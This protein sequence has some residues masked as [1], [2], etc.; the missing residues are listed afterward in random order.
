MR[1]NEQIEEHR[2]GYNLT[3]HHKTFIRLIL[4]KWYNI[5]ENEMEEERLW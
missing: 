2:L 3:N 1:L 4:L 5:K